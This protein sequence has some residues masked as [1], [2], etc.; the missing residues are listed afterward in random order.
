M[1]VIV[2][3]DEDKNVEL[4]RRINADLRAKASAAQD[5]DNVSTDFT[6]DSE[7]VKNLKKTSKFGWVWMVLIFLAIVAVIVIV[8]PFGA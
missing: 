4:S 8:T 2:N 3:K 6:E 5:G 1:G 7:Y